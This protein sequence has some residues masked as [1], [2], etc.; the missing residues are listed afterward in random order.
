MSST[1]GESESTQTE[2]TELYFEE[3]LTEVRSSKSERFDFPL[4]SNWKLYSTK[5]EAVNWDEKLV[6]IGEIATVEEFWAFYQHTKLPSHLR[7]NSD[8]FFFRRYLTKRKNILYYMGRNKSAII[9]SA[10]IIKSRFKNEI[11]LVSRN[12]FS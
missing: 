7:Q 12:F 3:L 5:P 9:K 6:L 11:F 10:K 8:Y 1:S 2:S 4:N